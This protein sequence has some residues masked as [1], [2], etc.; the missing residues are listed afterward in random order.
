MS[1][2]PVV[3]MFPT[4]ILVARQRLATTLSRPAEGGLNDVVASSTTSTAH[5]QVEDLQ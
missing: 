2:S 1:H 4:Q 3:V 5:G